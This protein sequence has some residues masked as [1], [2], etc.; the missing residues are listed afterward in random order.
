MDTLEYLT[1]VFRTAD[2]S[3]TEYIRFSV[4]VLLILDRM[5]VPSS[6]SRGG[7]RGMLGGPRE[8]RLTREFFDHCE[9]SRGS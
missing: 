9:L 6:K 4:I 7:E 5:K 2:T 8:G 1:A 3:P